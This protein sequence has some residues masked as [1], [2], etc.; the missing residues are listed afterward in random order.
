VEENSGQTVARPVSRPQRGEEAQ[1]ELVDSWRRSA[2][3]RLPAQGWPLICFVMCALGVLWRWP[4][5]DHLNNYSFYSFGNL[6]YS[7]ILNFWPARNLGAH[8]I[9]YVQQDVEY[10]VLTGFITWL[11]AFVPDI[12]GYFLANAVV[13]SLCMVG[14]ILLLGRLQPARS[15]WRFALAP[16]VPLYVILNWD[17]LGLIALVAGVYFMRRQRFTLAGVS[18]A[19]GTSAKLFPG[20]VLPAFLIYSACVGWYTL[21]RHPERYG[22]TEILARLTPMMNLLVSF[23]AVTLAINMPVAL[24]NWHGWSYF[25]NFQASRSMNPDAIWAHIPGA[26]EGLADTWYP[27]LFLLVLAFILFELWRRR[28]V[29]WEAAALLSV[30]DFLLFTKDYSPQYDLWILPLLA[31]LLCPLWLWL[32]YCVADVAYYAGIF[33]NYFMSFGGHPPFITD[34]G[35]M[36][37][38]AVRGREAML[39]LVFVWGYMRLRRGSPAWGFTSMNSF[40]PSFGWRTATLDAAAGADMDVP[41]L[42]GPRQPVWREIDIQRAVPP[43]L[44]RYFVAESGKHNRVSTRRVVIW[45]GGFLLLCFTYFA[46]HF[47]AN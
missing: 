10:P 4:S 32:V 39:G 12:H 47:D 3:L 42:A 43:W 41:S 13:L 7:D 5:F 37:D 17:A 46:P 44:A 1:A 19:I 33:W 30:L 34:G 23:V 11:T 31:L 16:A 45:L 9:P 15:L 40:R 2:A 36:L 22:P 26:S 38:Y 14:C 21:E 24:L 35:A 6:Q 20:F 27:R 8:Q 25:I 18:L 29:G 28:G